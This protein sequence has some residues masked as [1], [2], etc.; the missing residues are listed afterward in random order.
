MNE[1]ERLQKV[2]AR[3]GYGS[4]R[5]CEVLISSGRAKVNGDAVVLG[6]RV[7]LDRDE[8]SVDGVPVVGRDDSVYYLLNKPAGVVTTASDPQRRKTVIDYVPEAPR[9]F[10]VGRLDRATEGLLILTNDGDFSYRLQHPSFGVEKEYLVEVDRRPSDTKI[11]SLKRGVVIDGLRT[12]P[13]KVTRIGETGLRVT[14]HEGR[15]RQIRKMCEAVDLGVE[16]LVRTR[17]GSVSDR[18]LQ[19]GEFRDLTTDEVQSLMAAAVKR[20]RQKKTT[21]R[22]KRAR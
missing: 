6:T 5:A 8:V 20:P 10:P 2:L 1:G 13:A 12:E 14:I 18:Q 3:A 17:I 11:T 7:D 19:P 9:V 16:R 4:R 15:N 21:P 22:S